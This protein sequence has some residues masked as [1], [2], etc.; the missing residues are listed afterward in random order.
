MTSTSIPAILAAAVLALSAAATAAPAAESQET[1]FTY[2]DLPTTKKSA[3]AGEGTEITLKGKPFELEGRGIAVG[4]TLRD[5][6]VTRTDLSQTRITDTRGA[7]RILSI[8]P[9]L[10]TKVCEQQTHYL[11]EKNNG[12]DE[13]VEL[14][15]I[16]VD[17]PF[18]QQRFAEEAGIHNVTFFS[19]YRC[20]DFGKTHGLFLPG[21]HLL[22][23]TVMVVDKDNVIRR[24]QITPEIAVLPDMEAAFD[25]ARKLVDE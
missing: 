18:A 20:A 16:S 15:T 8:V 2:K 19:D 10:D 4:D 1:R 12:L 22:A 24:L 11:S 17:T 13:R 23:R 3:S 5:V 6:Q 25:A 14:I 21:P 7:V 9:S